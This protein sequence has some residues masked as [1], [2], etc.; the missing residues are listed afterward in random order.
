MGERGSI[1]TTRLMHKM[2]RVHYTSREDCL[3][4]SLL[5]YAIDMYN[6]CRHAKNNSIPF[7]KINYL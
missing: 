2:G 3:T 4:Q 5:C 6:V 1:T 7:K